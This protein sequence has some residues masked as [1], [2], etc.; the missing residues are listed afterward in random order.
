MA[1]RLYAFMIQMQVEVEEDAIHV[2]CTTANGKIDERILCDVEGE[3]MLIGFNNKFLL[4]ALRGAK[5]CGDDEVIW[6]LKSPLSGMVVRSPEKNNYY[7]MVVPM[8]LN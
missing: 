4:D 3:G 7:Y 8:R 6:E 5:D 1:A 2:R